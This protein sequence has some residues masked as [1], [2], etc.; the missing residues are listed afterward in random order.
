MKFCTEKKK[1]QVQGVKMGM[2]FKVQHRSEVTGVDVAQ[3]VEKEPERLLDSWSEG[4]GKVFTLL[5]RN[6][7]FVCQDF[8][9]DAG[10]VVC[11]LRARAFSLTPFLIRPLD[12]R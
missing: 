11:I 5:S 4:L 7:V 2:Q 10:S 6:Q 9:N 8:L 3:E 1:V 12:L